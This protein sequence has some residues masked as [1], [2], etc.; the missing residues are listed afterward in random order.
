MLDILQ[1]K[2]KINLG[3]KCCS[4]LV[5]FLLQL[6]EFD[7]SLNCGGAFQ[8]FLNFLR[9]IVYQQQ[10]RASLSIDQKWKF[11][12]Y[13][14]LQ[15]SNSKLFIFHQGKLFIYRFKATCRLRGPDSKSVRDGLDG[16]DKFHPASFQML[17]FPVI[18]TFSSISSS[19][20]APCGDKNDCYMIDH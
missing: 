6:F 5:W 8:G 4:F 11:L 3:I 18:L 19:W 9:K 17:G 13:R 2:T 12:F 1:D 16:A 15:I 10:A 7:W 14:I 20:R